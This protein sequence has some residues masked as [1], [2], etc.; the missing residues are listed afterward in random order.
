[1]GI[2]SLL[3]LYLEARDIR[4][5]FGEHWTGRFVIPASLFKGLQSVRRKIARSV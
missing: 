4:I 1:L 3:L 5:L 2:A